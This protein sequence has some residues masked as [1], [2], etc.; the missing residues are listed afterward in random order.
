MDDWVE[1]GNGSAMQARRKRRQST[2][3]ACFAT[4]F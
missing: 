3:D 2:E 4:G 1:R